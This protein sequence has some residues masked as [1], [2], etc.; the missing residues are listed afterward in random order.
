MG[1]R[2]RNQYIFAPEGRRRREGGHGFR[3]AVLIFLPLAVALLL[4]SNYILS[5]RVRLEKVNLTILNLPEAP[6]GSGGPAARGDAEVLYS[7]G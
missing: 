3:N 1:N 5:N 7:R 6:A 4:V 2:R